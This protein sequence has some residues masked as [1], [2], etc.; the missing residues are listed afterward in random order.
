MGAVS[1]PERPDR[2]EPPVLAGITRDE[3][4]E[5]WGDRPAEQDAEDER[6]LRERPPHHEG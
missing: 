6:Y 2:P 3:Q 4:D 5:G 1:Q